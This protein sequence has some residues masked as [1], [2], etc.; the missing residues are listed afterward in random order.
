MVSHCRV[1]KPAQPEARVAEEAARAH[2]RGP[3]QGDCGDSQNGPKR[4]NFKIRDVEK[5][6]QHTFHTE[7]V[8]ECFRGSA[9]GM[10]K[11]LKPPSLA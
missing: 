5:Y 1:L 9:L 4:F 2:S 6:Y 7:D 3:A 8:F 10:C 11:Q